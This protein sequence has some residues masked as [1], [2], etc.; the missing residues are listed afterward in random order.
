MTDVSP[1]HLG[2]ATAGTTGESAVA[3]E[4]IDTDQTPTQ[5]M[6]T[7]A[8]QREFLLERSAKSSASFS[9]QVRDTRN[10]N[11]EILAQSPGLRQ[12]TRTGQK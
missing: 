10:I 6:Y 7:A 2:E 12:A 8:S 9:G 11:T 3:T 4:L 1:M 5:A